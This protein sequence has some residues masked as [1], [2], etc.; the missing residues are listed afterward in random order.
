[1]NFFSIHK[2]SVQICTEISFLS[3]EQP[4]CQIFSV[5]MCLKTVLANGTEFQLIFSY[6]ASELTAQRVG[7]LAALADDTTKA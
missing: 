3:F 1:M 7:T 5:K 2:H 4:K 6:S